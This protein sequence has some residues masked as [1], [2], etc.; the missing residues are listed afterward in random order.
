VNAEAPTLAPQWAGRCDREENDMQI[1]SKSLTWTPREL[2][3]IKACLTR[4]GLILAL[5][6][7]VVACARQTA[8]I[9]ATEPADQA[10]ASDEPKYASEAQRGRAHYYWLPENQLPPDAEV[11]STPSPTSGS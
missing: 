10:A 5:V 2:T 9:A 6:F 3:P 11:E 8:Q 7:T 1:L 4:I